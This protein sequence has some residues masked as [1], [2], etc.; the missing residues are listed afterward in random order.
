MYNFTGI[1][2]GG[3]SPPL[4]SPTGITGTMNGTNKEFIL[5]ATPLNPVNLTL[6]L[7]GVYQVQGPNYTLAGTTIS[8]IVA[9]QK[10]DTLVAI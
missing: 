6:Y 4:V 3:Y 5:T 7:N 9:P 8:M 2:A 10:G 1:F